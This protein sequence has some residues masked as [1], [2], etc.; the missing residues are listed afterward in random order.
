MELKAKEIT[1]K[2][3][4][5]K[6]QLDKVETPYLS[7]IRN[8]LNSIYF[9]DID[10]FD[11]NIN[12]KGNAFY[13]DG[14]FDFDGSYFKNLPLSYIV[15]PQKLGVYSGWI[16]TNGKGE[17]VAKSIN[18]SGYAR[19]V[20]DIIIQKVI[21]SKE[22]GRFVFVKNHKYEEIK[23]ENDFYNYYSVDKKQRIR[24]FLG[25]FE[26]LFNDYINQGHGYT[27]EKYSISGKDW[28]LDIENNRFD[29]TSPKKDCL[30]FDHFDIPKESI[31]PSKASDY[32]EMVGGTINS[33]HNTHL[34]HAYV[35]KRK[36]NLIP[37][38]QWFL[39]KDFGRTG[40]GLFFKTFQGVFNV[41]PVEFENL[42]GGGF[43]ASNAW[44]NFYKAD[45]AHANETGA[46]NQRQMRI[47]RKIATGETVT[48]RLIGGNDFSFKLECVFALDTNEETDIGDM[49]AN[50][51]RTVMI[52][53]KER[54]YTETE[55]ER[56]SA[57]APYWGFI[58]AP[59][60]ETR[61]EASLSF[62]VNS[63]QYLNANNNLF[64]F[65]NV[66]LR[67]YYSADQLSDS[68]KIALMTIQE[69]GFALASDELLQKAI[70]LDYGGMRFKKAQ[71]ALKKIGVASNRQKWIDG[72]N[73]KVFEI[74]DKTLFD[75]AYALLEDSQTVSNSCN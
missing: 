38:E 8:A 18:F 6:A 13:K 39:F 16:Y 41:Q 65:E 74:G 23:G 54:P 55:A 46:I 25:V 20:T 17:N 50:T 59:T 30:Y 47:I 71:E 45:L 42:L 57:F 27:I 53:F 64:S 7:N 11:Q 28:I 10:S 70:E 52:S 61:V 15:I 36:M 68:Q 12:N 14:Q 33:K 48:A 9:A 40:K 19:F 32:I 43:E 21:Y 75:D 73:N 35:M 37:P 69:Q 31:Q 1:K 26:S 60:G 72:L 67:N 62:L 49:L 5:I 22:L 58:V 29:A 66:A 4:K 63:I 44:R 34:L 51:S 3:D 56:H 24:G 2:L